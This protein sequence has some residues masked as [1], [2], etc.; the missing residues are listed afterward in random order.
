[1][2]KRKY[3]QKK[4]KKK[5]K[6]RKSLKSG[7]SGDKRPRLSGDASVFF[8]SEEPDKS[9]ENFA[10]ETVSSEA[11][12]ENS[13]G[14]TKESGSDRRGR[15]KKERGKKKIEEAAERKRQGNANKATTLSKQCFANIGGERVEKNGIMTFEGGKT[16][17]KWT[18]QEAEEAT[19]IS[20][21]TIRNNI[22]NKY[23]SRGKKGR[24]EGQKVMFINAP[25][26]TS[27][28][29]PC[30]HC[31][32]H[33]SNKGNMKIHVRA[34]HPEV[35][36]PPVRGHNRMP[37]EYE[38]FTP[39]ITQK[40]YGR[41]VRKVKG[42]IQSDLKK[43]DQKT[44]MAMIE[45]VDELPEPLPS[46]NITNAATKY[47]FTEQQI[48]DSIANNESLTIGVGGRHVLMNELGKTTI[49]ILAG[50]QVTFSLKH[51][52]TEEDKVKLTKMN[53]KETRRETYH[54]IARQYCEHMN[55]GGMFAKKN[56][57][58]GNGG[59]LKNGFE[60]E[61]HGGLFNL[62]FDRIEDNYT[63]DGQT[64]YKL[65]YP[66]PKNALANIHVVALMANV[67]C[68]ASTATIQDRYDIYKN[69]SVDQRQEEFDKVWNNSHKKYHNG[70][71]TPLYGHASTF[72]TDE[73]KCAFDTAK[74]YWQHMLVLL[75]KQ[76]G[77]CAV[78]KIPMS[79]QSGPWLISCD[80]IDPLL[81]HVPGNLRLVCLY[82]NPPD[83]SKQNKD[84]TDT[85]PH[86]LTTDIHDEYWRIVRDK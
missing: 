68:K 57:I 70:K 11:S 22:N 33:F 54:M 78:A 61:N 7:A 38:T 30:E 71:K 46:H 9:P 5:N 43:C 10:G 16:F 66:D 15:E 67:Q 76:E 3:N 73:C 31:N 52:V 36:L 25:V 62:S 59:L 86:S 14:E 58:D 27:D 50:L 55:A 4:S 83:H 26:D 32:S 45:G 39:P 8:V 24:F 64:F 53:N 41:I 23:Q 51:K 42:N 35:P 20:K 2:S 82:N 34:K 1:M 28:K 75:E 44:L 77:L 13:A 12:P 37:K 48:L 60:F 49:I 19:G 72:W 74:A 65:H 79:L 29:V 81:G 40:Q 84:L 18:K 63:V 56:V 6:K 80:A 69:K 85:T 17:G 21:S 47:H